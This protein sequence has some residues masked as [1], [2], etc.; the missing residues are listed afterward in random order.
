MSNETDVL[1]RLKA[2]ED[3]VEVLEHARSQPPGKLTAVPSPERFWAL[4]VL[5]KRN[6]TPFDGDDAAGSVVFAGIANAA[7]CG[8]AAWQEEHPVP[9]VL[10]SSWVP[11]AGVLTALGHPVRLEIVRRLLCGARTTQDLAEIPDLGTSGQLYHH[12]RELQGAG[13]VVQRRRND[14]AVPTDRVVLCLVL[15]AAAMSCARVEA[16]AS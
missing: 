5:S 2:L 15:V 9:A 16:V 11:A 13:L 1:A 7:G 10:G 8:S 6:G 14:Y 4:D 12:L 3:R